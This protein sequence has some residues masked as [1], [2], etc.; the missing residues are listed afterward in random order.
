MSELATKQG[1]LVTDNQAQPTSD[2]SSVILSLIE[3]AASDPNAS[4]EKME[5][6]YAMY[7]R[8]QQRLAEIEFSKA[9]N[10]CQSEIGRVAV[11]KGNKQTR[12]QYASYAALDRALR[13]VYAKH[14]FS[15]SF[16]TGE[17]DKSEVLVLCYVSHESGFCRTYKVLMPADGKGAKGGDVMT[18]THAAGSAMSYGQRYLLKLIFNVAVSD[19]EDDDGNA[20]GG[21]TTITTEQAAKI[22]TRLE[23]MDA[24]EKFFCNW[25]SKGME[26]LDDTPETLYAKAEKA[27][28]EQEKARK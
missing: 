7:E 20:A 1:E 5:R 8:D 9:M 11:D 19:V 15:L 23:A 18:K 2:Q 12:S 21:S 27:I 14:G 16:D 6:M 26:S 10:K 17:A 25:L 24:D 4:I 3:R 22:R 28:I 13:P